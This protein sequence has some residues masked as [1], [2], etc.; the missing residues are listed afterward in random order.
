MNRKL[1]NAGRP[2]VITSVAGSILR[3]LFS[4]NKVRALF[5]DFGSIAEYT[6]WIE[7]Q[8]GK[9]QIKNSRETLWSEIIN[10]S[11]KQLVCLEL[12]VAWGYTTQWWLEKAGSKIDSWDGFDLFTGLP[13]QWRYFPAGTFTAHGKSPD[14]NDSRVKWHIGNVKETTRRFKSN[15]SESQKIVILFDLDLYDASLDS[16]INLQGLLRPGDILYFDEAFDSE[17]RKLIV[18]NVLTTFNCTLF[19]VSWAALVLEIESVK[20]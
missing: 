7:S 19:A 2:R 18:E 6:F 8:F 4:Q 1:R 14:I 16:W 9:V 13:S 20:I 12:G 15:A 5:M 17:E 10:R 11:D 3:V